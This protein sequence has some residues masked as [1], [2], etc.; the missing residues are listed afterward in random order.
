[1]D[2]Q[3][4]A[5]VLLVRDIQ[6]SRQFYEGL[7]EQKVIM[8]HGPNVVFAGGWAL[9]QAGHAFELVYGQ[10]F[11]EESPLGRRNLE[12][13]FETGDM[14]AV[15]ERLLAAGVPVVHKIQEQPWGQRVFRVHDPD[16]HVVEIAEPMAAVIRRLLRQ[17]LNLETVAARTS[18]PIDIVRQ[19]NDAISH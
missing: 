7:L 4:Q 10:T 16:G 18:M 15:W 5:A 14:D 12:M 13:Y 2:I 1:M 9:W 6:A 8:D 3:F 17:G 19:V 11:A